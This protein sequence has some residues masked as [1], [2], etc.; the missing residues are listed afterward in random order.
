M[1]DTKFRESLFDGVENADAEGKLIVEVGKSIPKILTGEVD[2]LSLLF[3][4]DLATKFYQHVAANDPNYKKL[5]SYLDALSHK[6]SSLKILEI[7]A[8]TGGTTAPI[9]DTLAHHGKTKSSVPRFSH[10]TFTDISPGF[11]EKAKERFRNCLNYMTFSV[12]N[13]EVDPL[14]QG[15]EAETYDVIVAA[16]TS[17]VPDICAKPH[18]TK[19]CIP[20]GTACHCRLETNVAEYSQTS[21]A[22]SR[23]LHSCVD[24]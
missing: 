24:H 5:D 1:H 20:P 9:L 13:I 11:F 2:A 8:G 17:L 19:A 12:L 22:V 10:Y 7:G 18:L 6:D 3:N 21:E 23:L 15:Y 14:A 16:N 4:G